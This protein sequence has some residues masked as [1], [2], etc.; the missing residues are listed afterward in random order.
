MAASPLSP[1]SNSLNSL[2]LSYS[3][4]GKKKMELAKM[5]QGNSVVHL[6]SSQLKTLEIW[7]PLIDE[8]T[9][10]AEFLSSVDEK[11]TLLDKQYKQ[12]CQYKKGMM[13]KIFSQ[14]LQFKDDSG[15]DFSDWEEVE[16]KKIASKVKSKNRDNSVMTPT[17]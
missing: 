15:D 12:L 5:A 3:I 2:F 7:L 17:Y 10:V 4:V 16:L 13:Q 9:R 11:I 8:Q 14:Q 1:K 6:Y